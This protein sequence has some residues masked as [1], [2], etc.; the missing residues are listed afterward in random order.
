MP[1]KL[2]SK[3]GSSGAVLTTPCASISIQPVHAVF[4]PSYLVLI[5]HVPA[6][7]GRGEKKETSQGVPS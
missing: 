1:K 3:R 2:P 5:A 6:S 4:D 7:G